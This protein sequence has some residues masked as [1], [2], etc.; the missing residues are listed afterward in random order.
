MPNTT[1]EPPLKDNKSSV[2][3]YE[4]SDNGTPGHGTRC[5]RVNNK[6]EVI[7]VATSRVVEAKVANEY[8]RP[9][10]T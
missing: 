5:S 6:T 1:I 10:Y 2:R 8:E 7:C 3:R 9:T 4:H